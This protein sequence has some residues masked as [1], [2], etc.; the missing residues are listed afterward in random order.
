ML[1]ADLT[2][3]Q[4]VM[5]TFSRVEAIAVKAQLLDEGGGIQDSKKFSLDPDITSFEMLQ[6]LLT[7]AFNM[8]GKFM[9]SYVTID[10]EEHLVQLSV[11]NDWDLDAAIL[12]SNSVESC[13]K[14]IIQQ[15]SPDE[16]LGDWD[17]VQ[18]GDIP[19]GSDRRSIS[20]NLVHAITDRL[21]SILKPGK[22]SKPEELYKPSKSPMTDAEFRNYMDCDGKLVNERAFRESIYQGGIDPGLRKVT[23]RHLVNVFPAD[24]NGKERFAYLQ[25]KAKEYA[26]LK[27]VWKTNLKQGTVSEEL[28]FVTS[29]V[30]KDV[31]RTDRTNSFFK[32]REDNKNIESLF[33]ILCTYSMNHPEVSYCQ[34]MS[35]MAAVLLVVQNDEANAYLCFCA[36]MKRLKYNFMFDGKAMTC[37]FDHLKL[38]LSYY[39]P[40]FWTYM[41]ENEVN[42]LF[43]TYRWLLLEMK[44]E[45]AFN[46]ALYM[47]EVMWSTLPI[48]HPLNG[49][50]LSDVYCTC[51]NSLNLIPKQLISAVASSN[52]FATGSGTPT[53]YTKLLSLVRKSSAHSNTPSGNQES[54]K[55]MFYD[56]QQSLPCEMHNG[57]LH[58]QE[59]NIN[60][61]LEISVS[62][63]PQELSS[64]FYIDVV[65]DKNGVLQYKDEL[66]NSG[67]LEIIDI[68][69][70]STDVGESIIS[71]SSMDSG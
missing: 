51:N 71:T 40:E 52:G 30:R 11:H 20:D 67:S 28:K 24:L 12:N 15:K 66:L 21:S 18:R 36:I 57:N 62:Q 26:M 32:G 58:D 34:G 56:S 1:F 60:H 25:S 54:I 42:D 38:L 6:S 65:T 49:V 23:W 27:D 46:D 39:D 68:Y 35:D 50:S 3:S 22:K 48:D 17:V 43:F 33:D 55:Q 29:M 4:T 2:T 47:L 45:F 8:K 61:S 16:G 10:D 19:E 41:I 63:E 44:R 64:K 31:I 69:N 9:I 59:N 7:K 5:Y 37:K 70:I 53:P 13:L 14:L